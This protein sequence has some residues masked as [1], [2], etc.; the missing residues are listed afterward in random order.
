MEKQILL[1]FH[2][3]IVIWEVCDVV[4]KIGFEPTSQ[5]SFETT[6]VSFE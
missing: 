4:I 5:H 2:Y 1:D 6:L 3:Q